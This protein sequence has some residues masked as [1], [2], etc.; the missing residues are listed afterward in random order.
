M[1]VNRLYFGYLKKI[2]SHK[3]Y[4]K[5]E[6]KIEKSEILKKF[7]ILYKILSVTDPSVGTLNYVVS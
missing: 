1:A 4:L 3:S 2:K 5:F 7:E 6:I